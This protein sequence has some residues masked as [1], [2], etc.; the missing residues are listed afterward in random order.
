MYREKKY[1]ER[2]ALLPR[3][4]PQVVF[5]RGGGD[6]AKHGTGYKRISRF[7]RIRGEKTKND[8]F[9]VKIFCYYSGKL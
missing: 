8:L 7:Q 5:F 9:L 4:G 1:R 3:Q 2:R 6:V